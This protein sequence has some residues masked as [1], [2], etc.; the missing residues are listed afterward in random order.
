MDNESPV[1]AILGATGGIGSELCRRVSDGGARIVA[2]A[3]DQKKLD[4]L[5]DE[6]GA[7]VFALDASNSDEVDRMFERAVEEHGRLDGAACCV[8]SFMMKP[9]HLTTDEDLAEQ[10]SQNLNTAFATVKA[11]AN[12]M[13]GGSIVLLS[14]VAARVGLA[15]HEAVAATK[16]AVTGLGLAAA[17]TYV[18]RGLRVNI[19]A[20]GLVQTPMTENVTGSEITRQASLD[21]HPL[22]R[23]GEPED[24]ASAI[25]WL[26]DPEQDWITGQVIGVDGGLS[27]VR[28]MPRRSQKG[29]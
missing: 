9:A 29:S 15:N 21:L 1:Y 12:H 13:T 6:H 3:R 26:L 14:S 25:A 10:V 16:A 22:N 5:A 7:S 27:T 19:V 28:P 18:S 8:G 17:A 24:I 23:L 11:A 20:P 2:G 4:S